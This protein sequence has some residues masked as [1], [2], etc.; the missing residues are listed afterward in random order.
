MKDNTKLA[1]SIKFVME[2]TTKHLNQM[3]ELVAICEK[4]GC[5]D[6]VSE[7]ELNHLKNHIADTK[8]DCDT[9][10]KLKDNLLAAFKEESE[11]P[12]KKD[13]PKKEEPV[14]TDDG[15][16]DFDE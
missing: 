6:G 8:M 16:F 1:D 2:H 14:V 12:I 3:A 10:Q 4:V 5:L 15:G 7:A 9:V 11:K 13:K